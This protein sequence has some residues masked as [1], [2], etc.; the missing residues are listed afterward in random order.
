MSLHLWSCHRRNLSYVGLNQE[1]SHKNL[2]DVCPGHQGSS[3]CSGPGIAK[4][5]RRRRVVQ[6]VTITRIA[7]GS[8]A[9]PFALAID[10]LS[11]EAGWMRWPG[12][13]LASR[14]E[15]GNPV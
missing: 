8:I 7:P 1:I 12:R 9:G 2:N 6:Q 10:G 11:A 4:T 3:A 14:R 5:R 15:V 13:R